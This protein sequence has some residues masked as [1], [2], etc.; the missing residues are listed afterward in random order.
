MAL[1]IQFWANYTA[2]NTKLQRKSEQA[3][4]AEHVLKFFYDPESKIVNSCV[5]ASMRDRSYDVMV[6]TVIR[7]LKSY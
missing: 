3:V 5:Q 1:S 2:E 4:G 7:L 6:S